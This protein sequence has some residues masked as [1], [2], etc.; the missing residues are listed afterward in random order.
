MNLHPLQDQILSL[1]RLP[2]RHARNHQRGSSLH[3]FADLPSFQSA[4][5]AVLNTVAL[6]R[7][8]NGS[9]KE[10]S[11]LA[12]RAERTGYQANNRYY[13]VESSGNLAANSWAP[14]AN[15]TNV[16]GDNQTITYRTLSSNSACFYHSRVLLE[17]R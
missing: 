6:D 8:V 15:F 7:D 13:R 10:I 3:Y 17:L 5:S 9:Q 11:F 14:V 2:F 16:L 12:R 4:L 1:A